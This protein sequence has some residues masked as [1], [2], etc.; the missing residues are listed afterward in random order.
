MEITRCWTRQDI[1]Q[2]GSSK[3]STC[4]AILQQDSGPRTWQ[5]RPK[6]KQGHTS[7]WGNVWSRDSRWSVG[8]WASWSTWIPP[9]AV[10]AAWEARSQPH[11]L[12]TVVAGCGVLESPT[13]AV[14]RNAHTRAGPSVV[15]GMLLRWKPHAT[16]HP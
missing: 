14:W 12:A 10:Q 6:A 11:G 1:Y 5:R 7:P 2:Q 15:A 8:T 3:V 13:L 9:L 4:T 16:A